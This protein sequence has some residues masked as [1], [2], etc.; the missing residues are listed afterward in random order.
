VLERGAAGR[1]SVHGGIVP[2][3]VAVWEMGREAAPAI[4]IRTLS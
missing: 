3:D 4:F 1:Q 2:A